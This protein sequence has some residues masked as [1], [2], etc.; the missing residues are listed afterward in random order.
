M[1]MTHKSGKLGRPYL[2]GMRLRVLSKML[3]FVCCRN[4]EESLPK[5]SHSNNGTDCRCRDHVEGLAVVLLKEA[6]ISE[7]ES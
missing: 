7:L 5:K 4:F 3:E 1:F 2:R 6:T